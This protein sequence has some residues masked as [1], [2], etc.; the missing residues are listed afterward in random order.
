LESLKPS[1]EEFYDQDD[2][3]IKN[4]SSLMKPFNDLKEASSPKPPL[5]QEEER[6]YTES[7][8]VSSS[9]F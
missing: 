6:V 9:E 4:H 5:I 8:F 2:E 1:E 7:I 3:E